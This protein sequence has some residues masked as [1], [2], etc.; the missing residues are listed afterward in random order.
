M[1]T[2]LKIAGKTRIIDESF[3][4]N[5]VYIEYN[6]DFVKIDLDEIVVLF[7]TDRD[8]VGIVYIH[9]QNDHYYA[10]I[11]Y[12]DGSDYYG[13]INSDVPD[14]L[15]G[16][17]SYGTYQ[18]FFDRYAM[19]FVKNRLSD[20]VYQGTGA[21]NYQNGDHFIGTIV[22]GKKHGKGYFNEE[23]RVWNKDKKLGKFKSL[24]N[25]EKFNM[26]EYVS[27]AERSRLHTDKTHRFLD[28]T[29]KE[30]E[31]L[32]SQTIGFLEEKIATR[33]KK[34][35]FDFLDKTQLGP[36]SKTSSKTEL[37]YEMN[38]YQLI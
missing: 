16:N 15:I 3:P 30:V 9:S 38:G 31:A 25:S 12:T 21:I 24:M 35:I 17:L 32:I 4:P 28:Q 36:E 10:Y 37:S 13:S 11:K 1:T 5:V 7:P 14:N 6:D 18:K 33:L 8:I 29:I 27:T 20:R 34:S 2:K 26:Y 23:I 22:N 19:N